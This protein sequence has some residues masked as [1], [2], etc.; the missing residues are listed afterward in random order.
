MTMNVFLALLICPGLLHVDERIRGTSLTQ[1]ECT[2]LGSPSHFLARGIQR[3]NDALTLITITTHGGRSS[4][5]VKLKHYKS[6][7]NI[8]TC[9]KLPP[10]HFIKFLSRSRLII[11]GFSLKEME[12]QTTKKW[13]FWN[14]GDIT[15]MEVIYSHSTVQCINYVS[16]LQGTEYCFLS[17]MNKRVK[18]I[19][20]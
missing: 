19:L 11:C 18:K 1:T 6:L 12:W 17:L 15:A 9:R 13:I 20:L 10:T 7:S 5:W 3:N 16:L 4:Q 2:T 8:Q 14:P